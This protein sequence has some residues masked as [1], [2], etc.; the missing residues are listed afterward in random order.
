[1]SKYRAL[2]DEALLEVRAKLDSEFRADRWVFHRLKL[3][4]P[5]VERRRVLEAPL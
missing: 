1:M 2:S 5:D 3:S 4:R